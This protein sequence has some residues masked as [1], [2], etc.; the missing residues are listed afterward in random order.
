MT[1]LGRQS[2][3][4]RLVVN[5][6]WPYRARSRYKSEQHESWIFDVPAYPLQ[7]ARKSDFKIPMK[8]GRLGPAPKCPG[9]RRL[10]NGKECPVFMRTPSGPTEDTE[11]EQTEDTEVYFSRSFAPRETVA[12]FTWLQ[13]R[14]PR[15]PSSSQIYLRACT[16]PLRTCTCTPPPEG[17]FG[18]GGKFRTFPLSRRPA[19]LTSPSQRVMSIFRWGAPTPSP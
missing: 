15:T 14:A 7:H 2:L 3:G 11:S 18:P 13:R 16:P 19:G 12:A 8:F 6:V 4:R 5:T 17:G 10:E 9:A 1:Q